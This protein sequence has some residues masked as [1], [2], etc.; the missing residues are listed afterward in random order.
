MQAHSWEEMVRIKNIQEKA[1]LS[2]SPENAKQIDAQH[3]KIL[4][5][6]YPKDPSK[7]LRNISFSSFS[8][9]NIQFLKEAAAFSAKSGKKT[10][11][12]EAY[13]SLK[14]AEKRGKKKRSL[15]RS[16]SSRRNRRR[17]YSRK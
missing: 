17:T 13:N 8:P 5:E 15:K 6:L 4:K 11:L 2:L 14:I 16:R 10:E 7:P 1:G 12:E 9:A 3:A